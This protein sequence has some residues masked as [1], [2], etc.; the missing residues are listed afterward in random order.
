MLD[1]SGSMSD[2]VTGGMTKWQNIT[3]ALDG[4]FADPASQGLEVG[5]QFFPLEKANLPAGC[6]T[7]A[8]CNTAN[9]GPCILNVCQ[10][11]TT[12]TACDTGAD[13]TGATGPCVKI[14]RCSADTNAGDFY[15]CTAAGQPCQAPDGTTGTCAN[16]TAQHPSQ[17][18]NPDYCTVSE[19]ATPAQEIGALTM[20]QINALDAAVM[21]ESPSGATPTSSCALRA[22]DL[23]RAELGDGQSDFF[24]P[25]PSSSRPTACRPS[26]ARPTSRA[27]PRSPRWA[28]AAR[29]R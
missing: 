2:V 1:K 22:A 13:C 23:A 27:S 9:A 14:F 7:D 26:A 28:R 24:T 5:I 29:P 8:E 21:A 12:L 10:N 11:A 19:Y 16:F 25:S 20:N 17:C 4:F 18:A 6:T 15:L 3:S